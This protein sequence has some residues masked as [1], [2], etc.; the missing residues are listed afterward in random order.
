MLLQ[1]SRS[2]P[3]HTA[4]VGG[5]G[6]QTTGQTAC[7]GSSCGEAVHSNGLCLQTPEPLTYWLQNSSWS[8]K[9]G[10]PP[11]RRG[12]RGGSQ[13]SWS[14]REKGCP[15]ARPGGRGGACRAASPWDLLG[16]SRLS[17]GWVLTAEMRLRAKWGFPRGGV[18]SRSLSNLPAPP[19]SRVSR[20]LFPQW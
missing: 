12:G 5:W 9:K 16:G 14:D 13:G 7:S 17:T 10:C 15:P 11:T 19:P 20:C 8:G 4:E 3:E 6:I 2:F 18:L 1:Y